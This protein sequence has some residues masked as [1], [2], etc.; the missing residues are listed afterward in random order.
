MMEAP[1]TAMTLHFSI[2]LRAA[3][4]SPP[5]LVG[6]LKVIENTSFAFIDLAQDETRVA[7]WGR[8]GIHR[9]RELRPLGQ[10]VAQE[11]FLPATV[12]RRLHPSPVAFKDAVNFRHLIGW[13]NDDERKLNFVVVGQSRFSG[14][15]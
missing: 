10:V 7:G 6:L 9:I 14:F 13:G 8:V 5:T 11:S 2:T 1:V 15:K 12:V 4:K 3:G